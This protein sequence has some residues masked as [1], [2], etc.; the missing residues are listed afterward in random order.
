MSR[1]FAPY[2]GFGLAFVLAA[3]VAG[4]GVSAFEAA[5][6]PAT[7]DAAATGAG[8]PHP[9][10]ETHPPGDAHAINYD[11]APLPGAAPGLGTLF[12][13]SLVLFVGFVFAARVLLWQPLIA[14]L[15]VREARVAQAHADAEEARH[16]AEHLLAQHDARMAQVHEQVQGLVAQA[17]KEAEQEKSRIIAEAESHARQLREQAVGDIQA[18]RAEALGDLNRSLERQ[19]ARAVEQVVGHPV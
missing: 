7:G 15:D 12:V 13:F 8:E 4:R 19:V 17:R 5:H 16:Q 11:A 18:A 14:A 9:P 10:G 3:F 6:S 1:R 2:F